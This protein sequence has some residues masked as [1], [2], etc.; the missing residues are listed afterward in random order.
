MLKK[1]CPGHWDIMFGG[2]VQYEES[3]ED[4]AKRELFEEAGVDE[5]VV[6][7]FEF[8][9]NVE[10][11]IPNWGKVFFATTDKTLVL[12]KEEVD[13]VVE[14]TIDQIN[15]SIGHNSNYAG[16]SKMAF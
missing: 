2:V 8:L 7:L 4:N 3:Y 5:Q 11:S 1:W 15:S 12:Q 9:Y 14:M 16:D 6:P 10:P 13:E